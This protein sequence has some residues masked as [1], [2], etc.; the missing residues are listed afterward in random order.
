MNIWLSQKNYLKKILQRFNKQDC[1]SISIPLPVNFKISSSMCPSN[2]AER[3]EMSRMSYASAV[4]SLIFA[5]ISTRPDIEQTVGAVSTYMANRGGK[6]WKTVK[7]IL[8][9]IK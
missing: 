7:M 6:H 4:G 8:R 2:E 9:Y 3:K 1:R 5:M